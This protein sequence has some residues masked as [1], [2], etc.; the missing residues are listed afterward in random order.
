MIACCQVV[1]FPDNA[2]A[3]RRIFAESLLARAEAA[4]KDLAVREA[5]HE[6]AGL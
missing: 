1:T 2:T 5:L 4:I 6:F 3:K